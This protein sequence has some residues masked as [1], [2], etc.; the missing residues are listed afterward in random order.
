MKLYGSCGHVMSW[1][2]YEWFE[3]VCLETWVV[4]K[5]H[6]FHTKYFVRFT[7]CCEAINSMWLGDK[8]GGGGG[9]R[10]NTVEVLVEIKVQIKLH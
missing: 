2:L 1:Q 9:V 7:L 8:M 3:Y 4:R 5:C 10:A 6:D